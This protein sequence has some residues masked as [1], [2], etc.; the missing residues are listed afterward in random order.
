MTR[1]STLTRRA[2]QALGATALSATVALAVTGAPASAAT[3][4]ESSPVGYGAGT[5]GGTGGPTVTVTSVSAFTSAVADSA[6][7]TVR[8]SGNLALSSGTLV[9]I[10]SNKTVIGVGSGSGFTGGGL[11]VDKST[12]VIIRNLSISKAVGTDA[13]QI[14]RGASRVWIDHNDLS[15]DMDHGKDFYD[16]LVD[17]THAADNITVS[18]NKFHNHFKVSLVG[19]SDSNTSEDTGKLHV[20]YSHNWFDTVNSRLPSLRFGTGHA[21]DNYFNNVGDSAVHS[22]M[23]AQFLVQNNVFEN[24]KTCI[25]TTGD[26]KTDGFVNESGNSFGGCANKITRT[27]SFTK[28]PYSYTLDSTSSVKAMVTAGAGVGKI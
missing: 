2:V 18:W 21:Y 6:A 28:A 10:G 15:S 1:T 22:R 9:K 14:I 3:A 5:T 26:S 24:T 7:R 8:V 16:G 4:F 13:I 25:E 20:T 11:A 12:N 27:G 23:N 19:H 17:I